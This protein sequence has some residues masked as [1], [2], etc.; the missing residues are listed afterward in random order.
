MKAEG[1]FSSFITHPSSLFS[2]AL[3][4]NDVSG[5]NLVLALNRAARVVPSR[6]VMKTDIFRQATK[7][8]NSIAN[9]YRNARDN[10]TL[11]EPA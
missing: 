9:E 4:S 7:E 5:Y 10:Q 2:S 1:A 6:Y 3:R 8:R 11:N